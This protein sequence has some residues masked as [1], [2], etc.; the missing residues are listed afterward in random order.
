MIITDEL[1]D[2]AFRLRS[3][4]LWDYLLDSDIFAVQLPDGQK[5]YCCVMG[6]NGEHFSLGVYEGDKRFSTYL[7]T[8]STDDTDHFETMQSAAEFDCI[9]CDFMQAAD[10][11]D[12][13]KAVVR[14]YAKRHG[15]SIPRKHGWPDITRFSP[16]K[17]PWQLTSEHD[18]QVATV[19]MNAACYIAEILKDKYPE[20]IGFDLEGRYPTMSGGKPVPLVT[21]DRKGGYR[22]SKTKLPG[23]QV[24]TPP[25]VLPAPDKITQIKTLPR[26]GTWQC[27][28]FHLICRVMA[29]GDAPMLPEIIL[30]ADNETHLVRPIMA[31]NVSENIIDTLAGAIIE[32]EEC[33]SAF[34][35]E[36]QR[37]ESYIAPFCK[38]A[39][40]KIKKV[41]ELADVHEAAMMLM[42]AEM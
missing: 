16:G 21:P 40:I 1:L 25:V 31:V 8:I 32:S 9:N 29:D 5:A 14:D 35:V 6:Y 12:K 11:S 27:K 13:T 24:E 26:I 22:I 39:G 33:P 38:K 15:I 17:S 10:L 4:E 19:A 28:Y 23:L 3:A 41:K 7:K 37:T 42:Y 36:D 18:V 34:Q 20:D 2:A 30:V